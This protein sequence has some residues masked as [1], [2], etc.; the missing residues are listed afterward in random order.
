MNK[1]NL[2]VLT[3][4]LFISHLNFAQNNPSNPVIE[5]K[6]I[7]NETK[8]PIM[9]ATLLA[10]G[11]DEKKC[12]VISGEDGRFKL[13]LPT[14]GKYLIECKY[15]GYHF[16]IIPLLA[17][18]F[19]HYSFEISLCKTGV[20]LIE[21]TLPPHQR[22]GRAKTDSVTGADTVFIITGGLP[23]DIYRDTTKPKIS[24][25][26]D[27]FKLY[28]IRPVAG[29]NLAAALFR[30]GKLYQFND[31]LFYFN[32]GTC[33]KYALYI[34]RGNRL[35]QYREYDNKLPAEFEFRKR[36]DGYLIKSGKVTARVKKQ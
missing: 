30:T 27:S 5:G 6:I 2:F 8:E 21:I 9:F 26:I 24:L 4:L 25:S 33:P 13:E 19:K 11:P 35:L 15:I 20:E 28:H 22:G 7:D 32:H 17:D 18:S 23:D 36:G 29:Y 3:L 1:E 14:A 34:R 16:E 12:G 31:S 10:N